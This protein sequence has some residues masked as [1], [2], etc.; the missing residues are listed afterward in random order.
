MDYRDR[1][2]LDP[3]RRGGRP[4]VRDMRIAV[5]DVLGW[6]AQGQTREEILADFPELE[7]DDLLACLAFAADRERQLVSVHG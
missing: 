4:R 5:H 7:A 6:L 3:A 1:V 2:T